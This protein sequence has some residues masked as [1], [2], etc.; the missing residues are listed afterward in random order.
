MNPL[1]P[2]RETDGVIVD[3]I[4][5]TYN[6]T[7]FRIDVGEGA[8]YKAG[9]FMAVHAGAKEKPRRWLSMSSS[10][11]ETGYIEF[12][13]KIT[14]SDFC[15]ELKKLKVGDIVHVQFPYGSFVLKE[16]DQKVA[17][18][19]GGIGIT[20]VRSMCKYMVDTDSG[21]DAV[22]LFS[23][24]TVRDIAFR[25]DFESMVK[26]SAR[27]RVRHVLSEPCDEIACEAGRIDSRIIRAEIPDYRE[28]RFFLCGPPAMV[29]GMKQILIVELGI[30]ASRVVTEQFIGY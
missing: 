10:P 17:F 8:A 21:V 28:R 26:C 25:D 20:P 9:Q 6:V 11:T 15:T 3:I 24:R 29:E 30:E 13:K 16:Q 18:L 27:L 14:E 1:P 12:T 2:A 23:N 7:S 22:V 19:S 5:R 4:Q